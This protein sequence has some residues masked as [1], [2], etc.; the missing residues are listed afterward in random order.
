MT[1]VIAVPP[2]LDDETF[3]QVIE[4]VAPLSPEQRV[5]VDA[6]HTRWASPYGLTALLTLAQTRTE[7]GGSAFTTTYDAAGRPVGSQLPGGVTTTSTYDEMG[8]LTAT[9]GAGAE[10]STATRTFDYDLAGSG[11]V[12]LT[13]AYNG[14]IDAANRNDKRNFGIQWNGSLYTLDSWVILKTSPNVDLAYKFLEFAGRAENQ[15][16]L[17]E[18]IAY[19]VTNVQAGE[20]IDPKRYAELPTHPD[21]MKN[22]VQISDK[23]W[24]ENIDR[25]TERFN[26]WAAQN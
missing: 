11:E 21:N 8:R 3:E 16:K 22:A 26:T 24:I 25:L 4:Q 18:Y 6:R 15:A 7:P 13:S 9:S 14:R 1:T 19:G 12:V 2:S 17:P 23:F 5:L 10:A 20:K